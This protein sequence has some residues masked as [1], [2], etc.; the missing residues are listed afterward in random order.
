MKRTAY[1]RLREWA[2]WRLHSAAS[3][4]VPFTSLRWILECKIAG[5]KPLTFGG[6][7]LPYLVHSYNNLGVSERS[8]E[9]PL[10]RHY[11]A[12]ARWT[13]VLEIGNVSAYYEDFFVGRFPNKTVVDLLE[14]D[15]KVITR[16]I[17]TF[18]DSE[19][20]DFIFSVSTFEHMDGDLGRDPRH[21]PRPPGAPSVACDNIRHV[22]ENLLRP[23][24]LLVITAPLA[25]EPVWDQTFRGQ[26]LERSGFGSFK[27]FQ[28]ARTG[29]CQWEEV[30]PATFPVH[31]VHYDTP[32]PYANHLSVLE[33]R[34]P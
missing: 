30:D 5:M 13:R 4:F 21:T 22:Y 8:V 34:K 31:R 33:I 9:M 16:D 7:R 20:F 1:Q 29:V 14:H 17:A 27:R 18:T 32:Y 3:H 26:E 11:L 10:I 23:G 28:F 6:A 25:Y 19:G 12:E 24:G 15:W 2:K